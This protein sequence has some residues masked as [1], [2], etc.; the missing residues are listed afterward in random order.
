M[1]ELAARISTLGGVSVSPQEGL[2][3][4]RS[5][6]ANTTSAMLDQLQMLEANMQNIEA[7]AQEAME[8]IRQ[9]K[10][11]SPENSS[12][13]WGLLHQEEFRDLKQ[14]V[15][16]LEAGSPTTPCQ[17][18][19]GLLSE[20]IA[21]LEGERPGGY[22][23]G[24]PLARRGQRQP[25]LMDAKPITGLSPLTDDKSAF[26]QWDLKLVNALNFTRKGYGRAVDRLKEC[27]DRGLDLEDA[28]PGAASYLDAAHFGTT[29]AHSVQGDGPGED[30]IDVK[31]LDV[32]LEYIE[33]G[34]KYCFTDE[35]GYKC[36]SIG[37]FT[38]CRAYQDL[39][40]IKQVTNTEKIIRKKNFGFNY[41]QLKVKT[42]DIDYMK[43]Q[44]YNLVMKYDGDEFILF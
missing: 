42:D 18:D 29:L 25:S 43:N 27:I 24:V 26:R 15:E 31:Q 10:S 9:T 32:D 38:A 11:E 4:L 33:I 34:A 12:W 14:R 13:D 35:D 17:R 21:D 2:A 6:V 19:L 30:Q 5:E 44:M 36:F 39:I 1:E 37:E 8:H 22:V 16:E 28:S 23:G 3:D 20:R 41:L 7:S 40:N